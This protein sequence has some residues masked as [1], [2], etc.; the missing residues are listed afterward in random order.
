MYKMPRFKHGFDANDLSQ[1]YRQWIRENGNGRNHQD[2][3]F[4]QWLYNEFHSVPAQ[5]FPELFYEE[6]TYEAYCKAYAELYS[7]ANQ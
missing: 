2:L 3:R 4:G 7:E 5:P 1:A 6:N